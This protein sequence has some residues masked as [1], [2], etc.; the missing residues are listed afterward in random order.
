MESMTAPFSRS[1]RGA[2]RAR[3]DKFA[4]IAAGAPVPA[5]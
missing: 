1:R 2:T 5:P 4:K 3:R